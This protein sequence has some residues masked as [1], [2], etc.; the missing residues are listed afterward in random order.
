MARYEEHHASTNCWGW[1]NHDAVDTKSLSREMKIIVVR[2]WRQKKQI[3]WSMILWYDNDTMVWQWYYG[4]TMI[5]WYD[6]DMVWQWYYGMT[7]IL[8]YDN[9][10]MVWQWYYGMTMILWYDNDMVWQWYYGTT[11][12]LWYDNDTMV[13]QWK[14]KSTAFR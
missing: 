7:M 9:D 13:W 6:N 12:I 1:P 3:L 8:W 4:M 5:L 10:T 2:I 14:S 11:M